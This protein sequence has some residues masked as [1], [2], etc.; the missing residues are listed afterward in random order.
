[1]ANVVRPNEHTTPICAHRRKHFILHF[2]QCD[3][4]RLAPKKENTR[5]ELKKTRRTKRSNLQQNGHLCV[6]VC[7]QAVL[8]FELTLFQHAQNSGVARHIYPTDRYKKKYLLL[9]R[10]QS[11][12]VLLFCL[13]CVHSML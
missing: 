5:Q 1:M 12:G 7:V 11:I 3:A 4:V 10:L 8:S 6:C 2:L 13:R 9:G